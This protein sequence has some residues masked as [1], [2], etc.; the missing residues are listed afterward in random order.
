M[1]PRISEG[2]KL[3]YNKWKQFVDNLELHSEVNDTVLEG[4]KSG[5][6]P[7]I[8]LEAIP[9]SCD[10]N[11]VAENKYLDV[12]RDLVDGYHTG[13]L[14]GPFDPDSDIGR[15]TYIA[16][17]GT[18]IKIGSKK[19]RVIHNLSHNKHKNEAVNSFIS[20]QD[21]KV[22]YETI[23]DIVR[24]FKQLGPDAYISVWDMFEAYRQVRID[25]EWHKFLGIKW[26]QK[27]YRYTCLPFGLASAPKIYSEFAELIRKII[28]ERKPELWKLNAQD[29]LFNY[30]DDY[31]AGHI[32]LFQAWDQFLDLLE[33]L[34]ELGIPTQWK[35]VSPPDKR[36][37]L[38]GFIFDI[39]KQIFYV[40]PEKV[41][42]ICEAIDELIQNRQ[43]S[44]AQIASVRGKLG[45]AAQVIRTA[46][47]F[48][49][50]LDITIAKNNRNWKQKGVPLPKSNIEDL[51]FWKKVLRSARNEM[52]FEYY[53]RD[54]KI[55]DIH[56][57][58]DAA[59]DQGT[60]IG[61][62]TSTGLYFQVK[63]SEILEGKKWPKKGSSGPEL[64]AV[65]TITTFLGE[66]LKDKSVLIH[67]DNSGVIPMLVNGKCEWRNESH[68][69]LIRY[70]ASAAFDMRWKYW[71]EHIP[72]TSNI[73]AD[74][75]SRFK[76]DPLERL[77]RCNGAVDEHT[78]PF[79]KINKGFNENWKFLKLNITQHARF[80][81]NIL[82]L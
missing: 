45:W 55:A 5:R 48:L 53:L 22:E 56:I 27:I 77:Y 59:T 16:P 38:L 78:A 68:L 33:V 36:Q 3:P 75:L 8:P 7:G 52:T 51:E 69:K 10:E 54:P 49:R 71:L 61:G 67:C 47:V 24:Y 11:Y 64:L 15:Q 80:C 1:N 23:K 41:E 19:D 37:K 65:V 70:F 35:K 17:I 6:D 30:L 39:A 42:K 73:E 13:Y 18:V 74:N 25:K 40:P 58:T 76:P 57:W 12:Y 44:R 79:F 82:Q 34:I 46:H 50:G 9:E 20:D 60:G 14:S 43:R 21:K 28:I 32:S 72:G 4:I 62:Y 31:W 2:R 63:W 26:D 66:Y 81:Y 29:L